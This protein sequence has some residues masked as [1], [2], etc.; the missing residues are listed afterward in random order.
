MSYLVK[1][2]YSSPFPVRESRVELMDCHPLK[3][4]LIKNDSHYYKV[5]EIIHDMDAK[6]VYV[7][8]EYYGNERI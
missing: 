5:K 7:R 1:F 4:D 6:I 8:C 2:E 3:D